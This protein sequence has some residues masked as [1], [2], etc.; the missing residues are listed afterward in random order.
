MRALAAILVALVFAAPCA[1]Q[2][3]AKEERVKR[4]R[5]Q[6]L[7][8]IAVGVGHGIGFLPLF[9][10]QDLGLFDKHAK[11]NGLNGRLVVRR[12]ST[13]APM[14]QALTKGEIAAGAYGIPALLMAREASRQTPQELQAV[15]G[16]TTLPLVL[17]TARPDIRA[18]NDIK[19]ADKIAVPILT[20]PQVTYLRMQTSPWFGGQDRLRQQLVAMPHQESLD[21]LTAGK[22]IAAYFSSP[23][24]TQIALRDPKVRAV[25]SSAEIMGGKASFLVM[26][27]PKSALAAHPKLPEVLAK[28][29]DEASGL[30]RNDPRRAAMV[31]LKW[32]PSHTLDARMV[33]T[34]LRDLKDD[35]GSGVFG[36]EGTATF[37]RRDNRLKEGIWS[38]KDVVAPAIAGGEG[39]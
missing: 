2:T 28:A 27:S 26:A 25:T 16:V 3:R 22:G 1:A 30:I 29:I 4:E 24:F 34:I 31:W 7:G 19:P 23:P 20:A 15:S 36:V 17:V 6:K 12:F 5:T 37:L 10:A 9:I 18:L 21:A 38:W 32:E 14:R 39:S 11:A 8:E 33:E 13:A 35:F